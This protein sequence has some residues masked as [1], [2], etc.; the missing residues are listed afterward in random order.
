ML[1]LARAC[2]DAAWYAVA[3]IPLAVSVF[4]PKGGQPS[5]GGREVLWGVLLK[6]N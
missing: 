4:F 5:S 1:D 2:R 3:C 6:Q